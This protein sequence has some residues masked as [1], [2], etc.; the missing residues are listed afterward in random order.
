[1]GK[2]NR[3]KLEWHR[4]TMAHDIRSAMVLAA[5]LGT[6]MRPLT[7]DI[8]KPLIRLVGRTLFDR[9][10]DGLT[11]AGLST[12]VVNTH[13]CA[14]QI[15]AAVKERAEEGIRLSDERD[16]LLDTGGGV[17]KALPLL[18]SSAFV[19]H[20]SDSVWIDGVQPNLRRLL[21][22][23]DEQ[24]MDGL[25]LLA[26]AS[27]SVGFEGAGD[28]T[29]SPRGVLRRRQEREVVPFVYS[30]VCILHPRLF[31]GIQAKEFS[32][33]RIWDKAIERERLYGL[34]LD[35][36]W[37]HVGT[38]AALAEAELAMTTDIDAR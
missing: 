7:D 18:G 9:V 33:N 14:E 22:A 19:V 32:L 6:R 26:L 4:L 36:L 31:C 3:A 29:M 30:G 27:T 23:W 5:G 37:M 28:F 25:L 16:R 11:N 13:Y 38:P 12:I 34:R 20:N 1:M 15:E 10:L 17:M 24:T 35:G 8:P 21:E 2:W